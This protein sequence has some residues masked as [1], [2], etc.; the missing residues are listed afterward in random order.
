MSEVLSGS[1]AGLLAV[2]GALLLYAAAP[3]Q[4][5]TAGPL[6]RRALA[7][8]GITA[9]IAALAL[10]LSLAGPATAVFILFTLAMTIWSIVPLAAAWRRRPRGDSR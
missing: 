8:S 3:A 7:L 6:P 4:R 9:L 2:A 10:L 5:L 1:L